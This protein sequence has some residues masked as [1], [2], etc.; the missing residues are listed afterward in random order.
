MLVEAGS[1]MSVELSDGRPTGTTIVAIV[2]NSR[3]GSV[4]V[5]WWLC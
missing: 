2:V 5:C 3:K 4:V 1:F